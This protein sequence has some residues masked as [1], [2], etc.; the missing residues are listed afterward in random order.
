MRT[1][2]DAR[3]KAALLSTSQHCRLVQ[4]DTAQSARVS[5][6]FG[7]RAKGWRNRES[8]Q[9]RSIRAHGYT[10]AMVQH[11]WAPRA[12]AGNRFGRDPVECDRERSIVS[13]HRAGLAG[14]RVE[15]VH[16]VLLVDALAARCS[17]SVLATL[18]DDRANEGRAM[19]ACG[20][21]ADEV[22]VGPLSTSADDTRRRR[23]SA[24]RR[25][26]TPPR[27]LS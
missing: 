19:T 4:S 8:G 18:L 12:A 21:L 15:V 7:G 17:Q 27:P 13:V 22:V 20:R 24:T 10:F 26:I 11:D 9:L 1:E 23:T 2:N 14:R 5:H 6:A 16:N 3:T 25:S